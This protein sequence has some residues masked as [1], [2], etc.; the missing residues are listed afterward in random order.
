[1]DDLQDGKYD[2]EGW[3]GYEI[4]HKQT[5]RHQFGGDRVFPEHVKRWDGTQTN[6]PLV[7]WT[8]QGFGDNIMFARFM[9][10]VW[11]R[12]PNAFFECRPELYELF[13]Y[14]QVAPYKRLFRLGRRLPE[15]TLQLPLASVPWAIGATPDMIT[16]VAA[17][18]LM[19]DPML[20]K[21]WNGKGNVRLGQTPMGPL[22]GARIGLCHKGSANSERPY[23][24]DVPK[25]VL[26][27]LVRKYGPTYPLEFHNQFE[28]FFMTA[29]A[30][31]ALDLVI[32]VDTSIAHLA[33]ALGKPT[34]LLLSYDPDFRWGLS[35]SE[36]I[37]YESVR[38]FRQP[39]FR[40]WTS[41]I[42]EV[43]AELEKHQAHA[44][45]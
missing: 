15:Y 10:D 44:A 12:A 26:Y 31:M 11:D 38:I 8:E 13:E 14:S 25:D 40:D 1:L 37:W 5:N 16:R 3:A 23:T 34:W 4:R 29:G 22:Q 6:E 33:G 20:V 2:K 35:G 45:S 43:M 18:Y 9:H 17:G 28:S 39:K 41:V 30:I 7:I 24:R 21:N 42:D 32:T 27:P 19:V 36:T